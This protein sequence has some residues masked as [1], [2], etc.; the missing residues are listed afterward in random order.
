MAFFDEWT[1]YARDVVPAA[2]GDIQREEC[3]RA[4]YAG[5]WVCFCL[6]MAAT[7]S[8]DEEEA[9]RLLEALQREIQQAPF[10]LKL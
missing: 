7:A 3:R 8:D 5:G 6:V 1:G 2:A 10:D 9:E 4:F